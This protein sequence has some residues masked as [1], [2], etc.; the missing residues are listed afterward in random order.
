MHQ[1]L[2][3]RHMPHTGILV[4]F[5]ANWEEIEEKVGWVD[6]INIS[7]LR[8]PE[9]SSSSRSSFGSKLSRHSCCMPIIHIENIMAC[10]MFWLCSRRVKRKCYNFGR[11]EIHHVSKHG[12]GNS[13]WPIKT[14]FRRF[15]L[16]AAVVFVAYHI[17]I[18]S[19]LRYLNVTTTQQ[20]ISSNLSNLVWSAK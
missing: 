10:C 4:W 17:S 14:L 1:T 7:A 20:L 19:L 11:E 15:P 5:L 2:F 12:C 3:Q 13:K 18:L 9:I 8:W 16:H 6:G